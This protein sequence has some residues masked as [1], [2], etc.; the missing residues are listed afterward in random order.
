DGTAS[1]SPGEIVTFRIGAA[2]RS[3]LPWQGEG[4]D[5]ATADAPP[6]CRSRGVEEFRRGGRR[7]GARYHALRPGAGVTRRPAWAALA[8]HRR[9]LDLAGLALPAT[10]WVLGLVAPPKGGLTP[11]YIVATP[12][13][14]GALIAVDQSTPLPTAPAGRRL[15]WLAAELVLSLLTVQEQGNLVRPALIYLLPAS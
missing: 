9:L 11:P 13:L 14:L 2:G 15:A 12:L 8:D 6:R 4:A 3:G 1:L 7:T 5:D 10:L